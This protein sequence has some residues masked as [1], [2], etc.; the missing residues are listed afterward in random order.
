MKSAVVLFLFAI[1]ACTSGHSAPSGGQSEASP[2]RAADP[3]PSPAPVRAVAAP[4]TGT[5][6]ETTQVANYTYMRLTTS[7]GDQWAAVPQAK[8]AVGDTVTLVNPMVIDGFKSPTLNRSFD[9]I[10][11]GSLA[12]STPTAPPLPTGN[13]HAGI[14]Q[15]PSAP[16]GSPVARALG[17]NAYTISEIMAATAR[18]KDK[19]VTVR[20]R[21]TKLNAAIMG[22]NWLHIEDGSVKAP[23]DGSVVVT[24]T[25][26]ASVGDVLVASGV[27]R[28]DKDFGS[29]YR[30][31]VLIE[32]AAITK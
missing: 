15:G 10:L 12:G 9:H 6:A 26:N 21:V 28:T 1:A 18:L 5:V 11:F 8:V 14:P 13:P 27:L 25:S 7:Q 20:G 29:G 24:T 19:P 23:G 22:K 3:G 17:A 4:V 32:D 2:E 16:P 31:A 30:Y